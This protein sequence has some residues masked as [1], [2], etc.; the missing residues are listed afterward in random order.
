[1]IKFCARL[2]KTA[3]DSYV[4]LIVHLAR[5]IMPHINSFWLL[6]YYKK[7][8][9]DPKLPEGDSADL[10]DLSEK[11]QQSSGHGLNL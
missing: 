9:Y 7:G 6:M 8:S 5:T 3:T 1:M 2:N 10:S 4:V 11:D